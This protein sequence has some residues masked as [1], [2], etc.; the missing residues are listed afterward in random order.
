VVFDEV[1][2]GFDIGILKLDEMQT[3]CD[4]FLNRDL[5]RWLVVLLCVLEI[6]WEVCMGY[7]GNKP[8]WL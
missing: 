2:A 8:I 5:V 6:S 1:Q 3:S 7:G 4:L